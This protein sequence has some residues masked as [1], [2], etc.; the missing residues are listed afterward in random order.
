MDFEDNQ[1]SKQL[2]E[3]KEYYIIYSEV[4]SNSRKNI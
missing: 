1:N 3:N 2:K 4:K